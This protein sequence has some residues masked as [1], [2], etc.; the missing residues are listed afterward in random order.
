MEENKMSNQAVY[1]DY[2]NVSFAFFKLPQFL[3][4]DS[5][6]WEMSSDAK[7]VYCV[8]LNRLPL[9]IQNGWQNNGLYYIY[10]S[11]ETVM[12]LLHC[13]KSKAVRVMKF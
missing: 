2:T 7:V 4:T 8:M 10:F 1:L 13:S 12:E 5:R 6:F 11:M 3:V 9:S